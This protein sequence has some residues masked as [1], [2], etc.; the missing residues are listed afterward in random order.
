MGYLKCEKCGGY[1][2][3]Q[4]GE[5]P[6]DFEDICECG[7]QLNY[8]QNLDDFSNIVP[9]SNENN[10]N[11]H[12]TLD[13]YL[14]H[15]SSNEN[16]ASKNNKVSS[17]KLTSQKANPNSTKNKNPK[18][19]NIK[20][21]LNWWQKQNQNKKIGIIILFLI[22]IISIGAVFAS[23]LSPKV[24]MLKITSPT[25]LTNEKVDYYAYKEYTITNT[26]DKIE[27]KGLTEPN[28]NVTAYV[29][30]DTDPHSSQIAK[31]R[32][33]AIPIEVNKNTGEF[34]VNIDINPNHQGDTLVYI[35]ATSSGKEENAAELILTIPK[36][37]VSDTT[38]TTTNSNTTTSSNP[39]EDYDR[40]YDEGYFSGVND[41]YSDWPYAD[42]VSK[43]LKVSE[44]WR[45]G[46]KEGYKQG[47]NDIKN[48]NSLK[49]P[50]IQGTAILDPRTGEKIYG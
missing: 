14:N 40:G 35:V 47:Y 50:R 46:Y 7:G 15:T 29:I 26:T 36:P 38:P 28:A 33:K 30:Y 10:L 2:E 9:D 11:N 1:Y 12:E 23:A 41:A 48:G 3:L 49:K 27:I 5:S 20:P 6:A 25:T 31:E 44:T 32:G 19:N 24:T 18:V 39:G 4:D 16:T 34:V 37:A 42:E 13:D 21:I 22:I 8:V 43:S 17:D 45:Q